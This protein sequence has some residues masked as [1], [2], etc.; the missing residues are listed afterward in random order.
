M[1]WNINTHNSLKYNQETKLFEPINNDN[2]F[3]ASYL[4]RE[5]E[6]EINEIKSKVKIKDRPYFF[7]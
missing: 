4:D 5:Y 7:K 1:D 3:V 6:E 2:I